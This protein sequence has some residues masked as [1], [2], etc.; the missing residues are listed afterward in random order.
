MI[1]AKVEK[2][3]T[4]LIKMSSFYGIIKK[5]KAVDSVNNAIIIKYPQGNYA[6]SVISNAIYKEINA[7]K[8][9]QKL[10]SLI[11]NFNLDLTKKADFSKI[12]GLYST[13]A[14]AYG[15]A[16]NNVKFE[17]F[18]DKI[19]DKLSLANLY[20]TYA[21]AGAEQKENLDFSAKISKKSL[22]LVEAVKK[23]LTLKKYDLK[24]DN[25]T[26]L[27]GINNKYATY[28][29][30]YAFLLAHLGKNEDAL[31]YQE[32]AVKLNSFSNPE[33]NSRYVSI[34]K[35]N[36]KDSLVIIYAEKFIKAGQGTDLM[37]LDLKAAYKGA[38]IFEAYY[39]E[40]EREV[41]A[42]QKEKT[43][44]EMINIPAPKFTLANL[45]GEIV[46]LA[47][48]KGKVV[49]VDYWATWC[50]PCIASFPG[51]QKA[52]DKYKTDPNVVFLFINTWQTEE[53][54]EKVVKDYLTTHLTHLMFY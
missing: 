23:E 27:I 40:L 19:E 53:N 34:L 4:D 28:L 32:E 21:W 37:K 17:E 45:K 41:N 42:R 47:K 5:K 11:K 52:V 44:K 46:D 7:S 10:D 50:G 48:L 13:I 22:M 15:L 38:I 20:N 6:F 16:K 25:I 2:K 31:K 33:M 1:N 9:E 51:M 36:N 8:K 3:E 18:S 54:R 24:M 39:A 26:S 43:I 12:V 14:S 49:I 30:T 29:D 35:K